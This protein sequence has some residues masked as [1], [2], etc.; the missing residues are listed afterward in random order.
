MAVMVK[1]L[2]PDSYSIEKTAASMALTF[3]IRSDRILS[4]DEVKKQPG[5]PQIGS[6]CPL[7]K[8]LFAQ[9]LDFKAYD[10]MTWTCT[11]R[12]TSDA[13]VKGGGNWSWQGTGSK[14]WNRPPV[15]RYEDDAEMQVVEYC[16]ND[17]GAGAKEPTFPMTNSAGDPFDPP[18]QMPRRFKH[19]NINWNVRSFRDSQIE[20]FLDTLNSKAVTVDGVPRAERT[21]YLATLTPQPAVTDDGVEYVEMTAKITY[22][23]WGHNFKPLQMGYNAY[24]PKTKKTRPIYIDK[25][26]KFTFETTGTTRIT[27]PVL[28]NEKGVWL[29]DNA[30][31]ARNVA[32]VYADKR[33]IKETDWKG[34]KIPGIRGVKQ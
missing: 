24:D 20:S 3:L 34:L 23:P 16:F 14:P 33:Y 4:T 9:S 6:E 17:S 8:S 5:V 12:Y 29:A 32:G 27:E 2:I 10:G 21:L 11:V 19:I 30:Y 15:I 1:A 31:D 28:L 25:A 22:K 26:G 7:S 18:P 13:S